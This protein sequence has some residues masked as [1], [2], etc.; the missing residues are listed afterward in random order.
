MQETKRPTL[1]YA[2]GEDSLALSL[3]PDTLFAAKILADFV[4]KVVQKLVRILLRSHQGQLYPSDV[5]AA[6]LN[7]P[8][9]SCLG[10]S[11]SPA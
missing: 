3:S 8:A 2:A 11:R 7:S 1:V 4:E 10:T 9:A 6:G 5:I